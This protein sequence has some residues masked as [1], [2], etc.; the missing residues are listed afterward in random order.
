MSREQMLFLLR[1]DLQRTSP[2]PGDDLYLPALLDTAAASLNRQGIRD[3]GS[4]DYAQ[5][6][7]GTAAWI[8]RKRINGEAE[9]AYLRR[10]RLDLLLARGRE[11]THDS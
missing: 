9:P 3:D 6:V 8:Y 7:V 4:M 2:L 11:G 1:Q 10:L 5:A